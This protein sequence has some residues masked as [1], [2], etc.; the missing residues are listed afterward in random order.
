MSEPKGYFQRVW[1]LAQIGKEPDYLWFGW[2][3]LL[4]PVMA[5][6]YW[7]AVLASRQYRVTDDE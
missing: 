1:E 2:A 4:S 3:V 6:V 5:P 7:M